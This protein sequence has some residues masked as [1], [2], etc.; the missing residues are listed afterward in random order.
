MI[1]TI[2]FGA[3]LTL[4]TLVTDWARAECLDM[5]DGLC[6]DDAASEPFDGFGET[7]EQEAQLMA[8]ELD[9]VDVSDIADYIDGCETARAQWLAG[10]ED[11]DNFNLASR[12]LGAA[13]SFC[14]VVTVQ[15]DVTRGWVAVCELDTAE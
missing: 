4:G 2:L 5:V 12:G 15:R 9:D 11:V 14:S 3:V 1:K 7:C 6:I 10:V 8:A 13:P